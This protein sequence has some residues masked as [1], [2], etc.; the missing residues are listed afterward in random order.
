VSHYPDLYSVV[1]NVHGLRFV[2]LEVKEVIAL[3]AA[4]LQY[5]AAPTADVARVMPMRNA[6]RHS[7]GNA[8]LLSATAVC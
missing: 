5:G 1:S 4:M 8:A 2:P 6:I 7:E 3:A